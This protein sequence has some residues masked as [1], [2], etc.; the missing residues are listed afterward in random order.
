MS[1]SQDA[2]TREGAVNN[3]KTEEI[4]PFSKNYDHLGNF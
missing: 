2:A 4:L 1:N 3:Q